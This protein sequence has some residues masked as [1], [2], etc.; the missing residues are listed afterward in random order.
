[1]PSC[2]ESVPRIPLPLSVPDQGLICLIWGLFQQPVNTGHPLEACS[3]ERNTAILSCGSA[4][5]VENIL[6]FHRGSHGGPPMFAA[7]FSPVKIRWSS[8]AFRQIDAN[9]SVD[10]SRDTALLWINE[11]LPREADRIQARAIRRCGVLL[12]QLK[13]VKGGERK[14]KC[15]ERTVDRKSAAHSANDHRIRCTRARS[16]FTASASYRSAVALN[17]VS[18]TAF[19][20]VTASSVARQA[21][22]RAA[23]AASARSVSVSV[24][25]G[26]A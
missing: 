13:P 21:A 16:N 4:N 18:A 9:H 23:I 22:A 11:P 2:F 10:S 26:R 3:A 1:M 14:S 24:K 15:H 25:V 17:G 19:A 12:R 6:L 7:G 8:G 20:C 5:L